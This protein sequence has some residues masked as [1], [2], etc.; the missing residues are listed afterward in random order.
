MSGILIIHKD[1]TNVVPVSLGFDV[2]GD[3]ITSQIRAE[4]DSTSW[5]L[6]EWD[7][8][9]ASDGSDG[10]IVL[11]LDNAEISSVNV[12]YGYMDLKRVSGG[13]PLSIFLE[14]L[15]VKFQGVVT[16]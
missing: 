9:F 14:P 4:P 7:V 13:E 2:S 6:C 16:L 5:L 3:V 8:S 15:K 10:E 11:T 1:R 12:K